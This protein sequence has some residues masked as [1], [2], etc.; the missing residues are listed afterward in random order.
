[1]ELNKNG[2]MTNKELQGI[3]IK[4]LQIVP[5]E[6]EVTNITFSKKA[7]TITYETKQT[8]VNISFNTHWAGCLKVGLKTQQSNPNH[9]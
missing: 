4:A 7:M 3:I 1:M 9:E 8:L 5:D 6:M 2:N